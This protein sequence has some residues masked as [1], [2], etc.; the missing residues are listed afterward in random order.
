TIALSAILI[1][2][3][4]MAMAQK[5]TPP[6]GGQPKDFKLPA[7]QEFDLDNSLTAVLVPYG[8]VPKVVVSMVVQVGNV[9]ETAQQN[10]LADIVGNLMQEGTATRNAT[11]LA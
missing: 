2:S 11:Q 3:A 4:G 10:G 9:H 6:E 8:D 7:K 5:Q 1:L